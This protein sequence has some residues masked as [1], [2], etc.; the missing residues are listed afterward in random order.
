MN[1]K[2]CLS[3]TTNAMAKIKIS[4]EQCSLHTNSSSCHGSKEHIANPP[5]PHLLPNREDPLISPVSCEQYPITLKIF[6]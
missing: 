3:Q 1:L 2:G 5:L 6:L 4:L